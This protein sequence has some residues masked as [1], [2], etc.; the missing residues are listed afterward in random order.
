MRETEDLGPRVQRDPLGAQLYDFSKAEFGA[1]INN[2][3]VDCLLKEEFEAGSPFRAK[4]SQGWQVEVVGVLMGDPKM[5]NLRHVVERDRNRTIER[6]AIMED[7][8]AE[9]WVTEESDPRSFKNERGVPYE[10]EM[11]HPNLYGRDE[12][13]LLFDNFSLLGYQ[14]PV[15]KNSAL[16]G[17]AKNVPL[18][19]HENRI[20]ELIV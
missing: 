4:R 11:H 10:A 18:L 19:L 1:E 12:T 3:S 6:P 14:T 5:V 16:F 20:K 7:P 8:F 13:G 2:T 17:L 15:V 9:P